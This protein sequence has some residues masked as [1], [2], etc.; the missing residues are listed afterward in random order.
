M[1]ISL[2][3]HFGV[4]DQSFEDEQAILKEWEDNFD[5][6]DANPFLKLTFE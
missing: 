6:K 2:E 3:E 5:V 4:Q 1:L